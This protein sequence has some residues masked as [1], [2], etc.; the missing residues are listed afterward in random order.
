[1]VSSKKLLFSLTLTYVSIYSWAFA[2]RGSIEVDDPANSVL[3][4]R[5][6]TNI[7]QSNRRHE[8][9]ADWSNAYANDA[10]SEKSDKGRR[11]AEP[12]STTILARKDGTKDTSDSET[13][14]PDIEVRS[15]YDVA[16]RVKRNPDDA[17]DV[18][19]QS[20]PITSWQPFLPALAQLDNADYIC[21]LAGLQMYTP[22]GGPSHFVDQRPGLP[23]SCLWN[24]G[25][26][27]LVGMGLCDVNTWSNEP[28]AIGTRGL[29]GCTA[30]ALASTAGAIV[31][32]I[33]P[34]PDTI[35][36]QLASLLHSYQSTIGLSQTLVT[37]WFFP[38][39]DGEG[40]IQVPQ[41]Q[42]YIK[43]FIST[44][45]SLVPIEEPYIADPN[46]LDGYTGTVVVKKIAGLIAV[47]LNDNRVN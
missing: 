29:C 14:L 13:S 15:P 20:T 16:T 8:A 2:I 17:P 37:A 28:P 11:N 4:G 30:V 1:M 5:S 45:M 43:N 19:S 38:P 6:S 47:Y 24:P 21:D 34:N 42:N 32:H 40:I 18:T 39:T 27:V 10:S 44:Q 36:S 35:S 26:A 31:A 7:P 22:I 41:W 33:S 25:Q 12:E 46:S 23:S 9:F 3:S